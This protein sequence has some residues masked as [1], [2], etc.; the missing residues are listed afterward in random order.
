MVSYSAIF[1]AEVDDPFAVFSSWHSSPEQEQ[2]ETWE[3]MEEEACG[4]KGKREPLGLMQGSSNQ[5]PAGHACLPEFELAFCEGN[6]G[7][8]GKFRSIIN[9]RDSKSMIKYISEHLALRACLTFYCRQFS[10][11]HGR[12]DQRVPCA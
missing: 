12:F 7:Q 8:L 10:L 11:R 4:F 1:F 9:L 5:E 2:L 3:E 6:Y